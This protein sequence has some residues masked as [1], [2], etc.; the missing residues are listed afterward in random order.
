MAETK[1]GLEG[2][3][4]LK[5][6]TM[7]FTA[8]ATLSGSR[9]GFAQGVNWNWDENIMPIFDRG[10]FDHYK[11][12]RGAGEMSIAQAYVD[13][14]DIITYLNDGTFAGSSMARMQ[15]ELVVYGT[16]GAYD[17][18]WQF[19]N[20]AINHFAMA[21]PEGDEG[22]TWEMGFLVASEP[23]LGTAQKVF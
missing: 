18:S 15:G 13:N 3:F 1:T 14:G 16:G 19:S 20:L 5:H 9:V 10:T 6:G 22:M 7:A 4:Y 23:T 2:N 11:K 17:H 8:S 21:D 12:G